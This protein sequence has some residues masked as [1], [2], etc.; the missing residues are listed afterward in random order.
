[1]KTRKQVDLKT[2]ARRHAIRSTLGRVAVRGAQTVGLMAVFGVM[3][4]APW[5]G[6]DAKMV[7]RHMMSGYTA[8]QT[9]QPPA[10]TPTPAQ[11]PAQPVPVVEAQSAPLVIPSLWRNIM[12]TDLPVYIAGADTVSISGLPPY[13]R[14][15]GCPPG[16]VCTAPVSAIGDTPVLTV[17]DDVPESASYVLSITAINA[18]GSST[19]SVTI[20]IGG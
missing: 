5:L 16:P 6:A 18:A 17:A 4:A 8:T 19:A 13:H 20:Q 7:Y 14:I 9:P 1:M 12:T 10:Q 15:V 2:F 11:P 3:V